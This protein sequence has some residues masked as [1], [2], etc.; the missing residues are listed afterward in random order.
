MVS[1][2]LMNGLGFAGKTK[3]RLWKADKNVELGD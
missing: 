2:L 3:E 1:Q